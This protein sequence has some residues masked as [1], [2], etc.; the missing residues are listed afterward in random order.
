MFVFRCY[1]AE[2]RAVGACH[3]RVPRHNAPERAPA[4]AGLFKRRAPRDSAARMQSKAQALGTHVVPCVRAPWR[5]DPNMNVKRFLAALAALLVLA[6]PAAVA[7][8]AATSAGGKDA[9]SAQS[10]AKAPHAARRAM[11]RDVAAGHNVRLARLL[12][13]F[14][15]DRLHR[16]YARKA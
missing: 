3:A 6:A 15:G 2:H 5:T 8:P 14:Q 10:R 11:L 12:A 4:I 16:N 9:P 7:A 13:R 1:R